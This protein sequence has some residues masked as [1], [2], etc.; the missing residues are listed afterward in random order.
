MSDVAE[1]VAWLRREIEA[2]K[3]AALA[4]VAP[5]WSAFIAGSLMSGAPPNDE[6]FCAVFGEEFEPDDATARHIA[7]HDPQDV[8]ADCDAKLQIVRE[9]ST[10]TLWNWPSP[11]DGSV[12]MEYVEALR[13]VLKLLAQGYRHRDGW[14][15]EWTA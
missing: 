12:P 9:L 6:E 15:D 10:V 14:K 5:P 4:A 11:A 2:D 8:I 3:A 13:H 1:M 7:R